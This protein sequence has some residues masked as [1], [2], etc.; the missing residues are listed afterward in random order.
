MLANIDVITMIGVSD[1]K[2]AREFYG[3]V[4]GFET[5]ENMNDFVVGYRCGQ[6]RVNVY[7][8]QFAGTNKATTMMWNVGGDVARIAEE[9][10]AKGVKFL[11]YEMPGMTLEG[12]VHIGN[13][14][15]VAWFT[16]PDGNIL[17][18]GGR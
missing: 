12:D 6:S 18:I 13:N 15:K 10:A 5:I 16:D 8:S 9:L 2:K 3:G 7:V 17:S 1:M 4:L 11:H 14:H